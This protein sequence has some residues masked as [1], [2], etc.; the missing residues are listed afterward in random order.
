[1]LFEPL[2]ATKTTPVVG[3]TT[4]AEGT[5]PVPTLFPLALSEPLPR[6]TVKA[7]TVVFD[8]AVTNKSP[9]P[10]LVKAELLPPHA[11]KHSSKTGSITRCRKRN[12][13]PIHSPCSRFKISHLPGKNLPCTE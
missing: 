9:A 7:E 11:I 2:L 13:I 1:M 3:V 8:C 5:A 6:S 4:M 12:F 10:P